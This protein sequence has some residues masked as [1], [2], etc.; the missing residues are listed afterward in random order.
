MRGR[1]NIYEATQL[2]HNQLHSENIF[3]STVEFATGLKETILDAILH[4]LSALWDASIV[5]GD[6]RRR[7]HFT[8]EHRAS[9]SRSYTNAGRNFTTSIE[10][11]WLLKTLGS[12]WGF[13]VSNVRDRLNNGH[14]NSQACL[15]VMLL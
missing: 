5:R 6:S 15:E 4:S 12:R 8:H 9:E 7:I 13:K 10:P 2:P 11:P 1:S 14:S 3:A